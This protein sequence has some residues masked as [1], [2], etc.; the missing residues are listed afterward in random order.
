MKILARVFESFKSL[1]TVNYHTLE[2]TCDDSQNLLYNKQF[3]H[4][5]QFSLYSI[6]DS[7]V[8]PL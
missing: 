7:V 4:F 2:I 5:K 8:E 3:S 6:L 1:E